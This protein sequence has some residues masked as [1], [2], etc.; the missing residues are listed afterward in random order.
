[1]C[2]RLRPRVLLHLLFPITVVGL[3]PFYVSRLP[4]HP[5]LSPSLLEFEIFT[6]VVPN[7]CKRALW[8]M[9]LTAITCNVNEIA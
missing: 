5:A 8:W 2:L 4:P 1:M 3:E 6:S 9:I 7:G